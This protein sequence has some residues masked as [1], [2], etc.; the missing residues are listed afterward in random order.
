MCTKGELLVGIFFLQYYKYY[1]LHRP[2]I[3]RTNNRP[4]TWIQC[5]EFWPALNSPFIT[6]RA[7]STRTLIPCYGHR[8]PPFLPLWRRK[9]WSATRARLLHPYR[10]PRLHRG[11]G[12]RPSSTRLSPPGRP[13]LEGRITNRGRN[14]APVPGP[15]EVTGF[16]TCITTSH[17]LWIVG[18]ERAGRQ[19]GK[20]PPLH[21]LC[22]AP[23]GH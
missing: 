2:F 17:H 20:K 15:T 3:L 4:L 22:T 23:L 21:P 14:T 6:A 10:H 8:M 5:L 7:P 12:K 11:R 9:S 1:L 18:P 19:D 16:L 13:A